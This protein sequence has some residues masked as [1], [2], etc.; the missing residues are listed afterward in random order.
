M[1]EETTDMPTISRGTFVKGVTAA[2]VT[3]AVS[4]AVADVVQAAGHSAVPY[5]KKSPSGQILIWVNGIPF[6]NAQVAAFNKVYPNVK[7]KQ[8]VTT[9]VPA[10][11][12]LSAHLVTGIN[13]PDGIFF[14]EDAYLGQY[15]PLLYDVSSHVAPYAG[16]IAP[17]KLA[18]SKQE[19]RTVAVPWDVD[20]AFLIYR[21]D[22]VAKAGVDVARIKTYDDLIKAAVQV[23]QKVPS[24]KTPLAF[25]RANGFLTFMVEGLAWQQHSGI[26]D[27]KGNLRLNTQPY[28]NAFTYLEKA[29]KAG[30]VTLTDWATPSLYNLWNKGQASFMHFADWFTHWNEPG[31]KASWG[32]IGLA[33]QPVFS[34]QDSPYS[35]MGGSGFA[36]PIKAK[37]PDL[38][39]LFATFQMFDP[40]ALKAGNSGRIYEAVLPAAEAL[41][42][43]VNLVRPIISN[44][45]NEHE[46]LVTAA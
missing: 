27:A 5:V 1:T 37:N 10:T 11:P 44:K 3:A 18:V 21:T 22:I 7:V 30:I 9:Y 31:L 33:R 45:I 20:P 8:Q 36:I 25:L 14:I 39:A 29:Y 2:T 19:G 17:Y 35:M 38:G 41:W 15:A 32:K 4:G 12:S 46:M 23:K 16:K 40:R 26:A 42:P 6:T 13:V 24:C 28:T 34:S 43:D